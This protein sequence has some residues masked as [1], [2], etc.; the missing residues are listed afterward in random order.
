MQATCFVLH[1]TSIVTE[2]GIK[3]VGNRTSMVSTSEDGNAKIL[4]PHGRQLTEDPP[5]T[6][7]GMVIADLNLDQIVQDDG[8]IDTCGHSNGSE[9]MW[10]G[11]N[12]SQ[13]KNPGLE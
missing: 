3:K 11:R 1:F 5:I 7:E 10:L 12:P 4:G 8:T 9:L 13:Q 6:E 2:K